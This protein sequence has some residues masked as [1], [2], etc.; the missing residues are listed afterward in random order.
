MKNLKKY[1]DVPLL[2]IMGAVYALLSL[3]TFL[4]NVYLKL[5]G[6]RYKEMNWDTLIVKVHLYDWFVVMLF[7]SVVGIISGI[8]FEKKV[9]WYYQLIFH[10]SLSIFIGYYM[11]ITSVLVEVLLGNASFSD[12]SY[13]LNQVRI[14]SVIDLNFLLYI[15]LLTIIYV[16]YY[17][18]RLRNIELQ[19]SDLQIQL[20]KAKLNA[21]KS[22]LHPHFLFNTLNS[23][24]S[25][26]ITDEEKSEAMLVDMSDLL[27]EMIDYKDENLIELQDEI[28]LLNK[29]LRIQKSRFSN[30]LKI[31]LNLEEKLENVLV[32]AMLLQP[33][34]ENLIN[35]CYT[36]K[37]SKL[38]LSIN[39]FKKKNSTVFKIRCN[40]KIV[41]KTLD[42]LINNEI[43]IKN[44]IERLKTLYN[45][46][47][48]FETY[49]SKLGVTSKIKIPYG[50][51]EFE[52]IKKPSLI[53][54][55]N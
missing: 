47:F 8:M 50:I 24:H 34:A 4:K 16:Y 30:N 41:K 38:K 3:T 17:F 15:S 46:D 36:E 43:S 37:E 31:E 45:N 2:K 22:Q 23:I 40:C 32:P 33:I 9:K 55:N 39:I 13:T 11:Y 35:L 21:L 44:I 18:N 14:I 49:N 29:Y 51:A 25:L 12:Y 28:S 7:M 6:H 5:N 52:L 19:K 27:R 42:E 53:E 26:M 48:V 1:I 10:F 20:S 54:I